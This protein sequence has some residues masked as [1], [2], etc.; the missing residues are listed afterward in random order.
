MTAMEQI[1]N[2]SKTV[3][4]QGAETR[5]ALLTQAESVAELARQTGILGERIVHI[6]EN[7]NRTESRVAVLELKYGDL[8]NTV[9]L[10]K[11]ARDSIAKIF[12]ALCG[13]FA[14]AFSAGVMFE[15]SSKNNVIQ[16]PAVLK[17]VLK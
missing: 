7:N 16:N 15:K 11:F 6:M 3:E 5:S 8:R 9:G 12:F 1:E 4:E 10:N 13:A 17:K 2:L 14:V